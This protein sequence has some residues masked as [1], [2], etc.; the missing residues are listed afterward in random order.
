MKGRQVVALSGLLVAALVAMVACNGRMINVR[1]TFDLQIETTPGP[2]ATLAALK[3]EKARLATQVAELETQSDP[4][5]LAYI[6]DGDVWARRLPD[7]EPQRLTEDGRNSTPSWSPSGDWLAFCKEDEVWVMRADGTDAHRVAAASHQGIIWSPV[8]DRL[9][10][11][12][13]QSSLRVIEADDLADTGSEGEGHVILQLAIE[14]QPFTTIQYPAWSPDGRRLAYVL[15]IGQP[16]ALPDHVSIGYVDLEAGPRELYAPPGPP[17]DGLI[18]ASWTPDGQSLL[19][20]RDPMFSASAAADGLPLLRLPLD[21]GEPVEVADFML[22]H[23]DFWSGSPTGQQMVLTVGAGRETWT[24]KL[25]A[26]VNLETAGCE[27]LTGETVSAFSP[28]FSPDGRHI[29]YVAAPDVGHVW[30]GDDAKAGAAQR[31]IWVMNTDGSDQ[32]PLTSDLA[33]RDER[34]L[35][36]ADG[37]HV[38]F[39]RLDEHGR[40]SLWLVDAAGDTPEQVAGQLTPAPEWFGN[41][42]HIAWDQWFDWWRGTPER[43]GDSPR[44]AALPPTSTHMPAPTQ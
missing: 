20:W 34:P 13:G 11:V 29:A 12:A 18:L 25:I 27:Y 32:H 1:R 28:A 15:Q 24:N 14:E 2:E 43:P 10:Y 42:G 21:G 38:L 30:G 22:L 31:R 19:F 44:D 9:A 5:W 16:Q 40:A 8:A 33:Y 17:Q 41:Y 6:H 3:A 35:W 23:P 26:L 7:G 37:T 36:S 39:A 4:G